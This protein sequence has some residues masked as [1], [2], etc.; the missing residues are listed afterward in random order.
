MA[1]ARHVCW[2]IILLVISCKKDSEIVPDI[3]FENLK[4]NA[5]VWNTISLELGVPDPSR[6]DRIEVFIG[7]DLLVTLHQPPYSLSWNTRE[8]ED[9]TYVLQAT[10]TDHQGLQISTSLTITVRNLLLSVIVPP[11]QLSTTNG[12]Q[13][14]FLFLSD[15]DGKTI[16]STEYMNS[17]TV[18]IPAPQD[19]Q[20]GIFTLNEA[21][22][23]NGS[24]LQVVSFQEVPR[25]KWTLA[26]DRKANPAVGDITLNFTVPAE[27]TYYISCNGG[28]QFL[29]KDE[30]LVKLNLSKSPSKLFIRE[31]GRP[32]NYYKI[33]DDLSP[34]PHD[35]SLSDVTHSLSKVKATVLFSSVQTARVTLYGFP[36]ANQFDEYYE[37]GQ[38]FYHDGDFDVAYPGTDFPV[39]GSNSHYRNSLLIM[40][41]FHPDKL[42]DFTPLQAE[43]NFRETEKFTV[44]VATYGDFE[45]YAIGWGYNDN[46]QGSELSWT[47]IGANGRNQTVKLPELPSTIGSAVPKVSLGSAYFFNSLQVAN[48]GISDDYASYLEFIS[49]HGY[50]APFRFGNAWKEQ[51]FFGSGTTGGRNDQLEPLPLHELLTRRR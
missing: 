2:F 4:D 18:K 7:A 31:V 15:R 8:K 11:D 41:A 43:V 51:L 5:V 34:G 23:S 33:M 28:Y 45:T 50:S 12:I 49:A 35:V 20:D 26:I 9:G 6:I 42:F 47:M 48:Y 17:D 19:F 10:R 21:Y 1:R 40:D 44:A 36:I 13:R 32:V 22:T 25:G 3:F 16:V 38:F 37:L 39:Y 46:Q 14:G 24:Y 27:D 29:N 30:D